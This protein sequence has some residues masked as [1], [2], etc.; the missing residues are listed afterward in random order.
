MV[1]MC[2]P[3]ADMTGCCARVQPF[4]TAPEPFNEGEETL[5]TTYLTYILIAALQGSSLGAEQEPSSTVHLTLKEALTAATDGNPIL[6]SS[7][8]RIAAAEGLRTQASLKPNPRLVIQTEN[9]RMWGAP[10]LEYWRD[11]DTYLYGA[12]VL[13]RGGKRER[14]VDYAAA[15]VARA[16]SDRV[17]L[18]AQI[19]AR[20]AVAY[21]SAASASRVAEL[22]KQDLAT[23]EQIVE[24]NRSRVREGATAGIDLLRIE[25]ERDQLS[26]TTRRA[27]QDSEIARVALFREMGKQQFPPLV[28][29]D[30]LESISEPTPSRLDEVLRRRKDVIAAAAAVSQMVRNV[31]LQKANA[32]TDPEVQF[33]YKRTLGFD[34]LYGAVS[35]PLATRNRNQGN[36][37]AAEAELR[38]AVHTAEALHNQVRAE[39]EAARLTYELRRAALDQTIRPLRGK[40]REVSRIANAAYREGGVELLRFLDAE[41][42][43]IETEV[44]YFRSLAELQQ[45]IVTL[46]IAQGDEL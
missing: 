44:L 46:K 7:T 11:T 43:R 33:G 19:K 9:S 21:W 30:A 12:Q 31:E 16:Q 45:S 41:R 22:Y 29:S 27:E 6:L 3:V 42:I 37:A 18:E 36:I 28:L 40:T 32:K 15:G 25:V 5:K 17:A 34:T 13:E 20:V 39:W 23:F 8:D 10:G 2:L 24:F 14:R 4:L 35:I 38:N 26:T 1:R